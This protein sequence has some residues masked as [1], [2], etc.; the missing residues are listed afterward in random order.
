MEKKLGIK[1]KLWSTETEMDI[2]HKT[3]TVTLT[4]II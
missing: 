2:Q 1:Y 4:L 3:D